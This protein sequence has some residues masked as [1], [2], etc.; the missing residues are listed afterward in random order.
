[1]SDWSSDVCSSDLRRPRP[2]AGVQVGGAKVQDRLAIQADEDPLTVEGGT[3]RARNTPR[4]PTADVRP[5]RVEVPLVTAHP[6]SEDRR[7]GKDGVSPCR[8]RGPRYLEQKHHTS[9]S[10]YRT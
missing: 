6:R 1:M 3:Q 2:R 4:D 5:H 9:N 10:Q 7:V 8:S